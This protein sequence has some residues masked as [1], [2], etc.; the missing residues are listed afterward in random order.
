MRS[1]EVNAAIAAFREK[2]QVDAPTAP[3][4]APSHLRGLLSSSAASSGA[5]TVAPGSLVNRIIFRGKEGKGLRSRPEFLS[6]FCTEVRSS[7]SEGELNASSSELCS[8]LYRTGVYMSIQHSLEPPPG[9]A[10]PGGGAGVPDLVVTL[11][12]GII[13]LNTGQALTTSGALEG[14][15]NASLLN[16]LGHGETLSVTLGKDVPLSYGVG[17]GDG[18]PLGDAM[19][20]L[21]S[22][23]SPADI[24]T[25]AAGAA[26]KWS[27]AL[28][29]PTLGGTAYSLNALVH[30]NTTP[31]CMGSSL[32]CKIVEAQLSL[33]DPSGVHSLSLATALRNLSPLRLP[34]LAGSLT[35]LCSAETL[36]HA[37]ASVKNSLTYSATL[38]RRL[39]ASGAEALVRAE[40]A[41]LGGDVSFFKLALT[42]SY[43][44]SAWRFAP[45]TG[46][47]LP[48]GD[49]GNAKGPLKPIPGTASGGSAGAGT[50]LCQSF[51]EWFSPGVT[52]ALDAF[53]GLLVPLGRGGAAG[54]SGMVDRLFP[55]LTGRIGKGLASLG[56]RGTPP[57][58]AQGAAAPALAAAAAGGGGGP[59]R[60]LLGG[61]CPRCGHCAAPPAPPPAIPDPRG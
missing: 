36:A 13:H 32:N 10:G 40:L 7:R 52:L 43:A 47:S 24:A 45:D 26:P 35:T 39:P 2:L 16:V 60:G 48:G 4:E 29:K 5:A 59:Q 51:A 53:A 15:L 37:R 30:G 44:A 1:N 49:A 21:P 58:Q 38:G 3:A 17:G 9:Q 33:T 12:E 22:N 34:G 31:L 54:Q 28:R 14:G 57:A 25:I 18:S 55:P 46:Y 6:K 8:R 56:Q 50:A 19:G 42:G 61:G 23:S 20:S 41:G 11:D 27:V